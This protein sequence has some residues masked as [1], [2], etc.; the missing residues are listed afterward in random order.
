MHALCEEALLRVLYYA[1]EELQTLWQTGDTRLQLKLR[2]TVTE[3]H[4]RLSPA[5]PEIWQQAKF[6][7]LRAVALT[8]RTN[9]PKRTIDE[10]ATLNRTHPHANLLLRELLT[11][12]EQNKRDARIRRESAIFDSLSATTM[13]K[14]I[15][16][17]KVT[18]VDLGRAT[19][20]WFPNLTSLALNA[21]SLR[22][23]PHFVLAPTL[24]TLTLADNSL[25]EVADKVGS[26][27]ALTC[28]DLQNNLI[29]YLSFELSQLPELT[30]LNLAHNA[31]ARLPDTM[32]PPD[33][34]TALEEL[35]LGDNHLEAPFPGFYEHR[36]NL[37]ALNLAGANLHALP[38]QVSHLTNLTSLNV[39]ACGLSTLP[40]ELGLLPN[41]IDLNINSDSV[42][43]IPDGFPALTEL[44]ACSNDSIVIDF[45]RACPRLECLALLWCGAVRLEHIARLSRLQHLLL[46]GCDIQ[47]LPNGLDQ[48]VNLEWLSVSECTDLMTISESVLKLPC[49]DR[50][51]VDK[52]QKFDITPDYQDLVFVDSDPEE[53]EDE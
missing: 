30:R 47:T 20:V 35:D 51:S 24:Q 48:C 19:Q 49:L 39:G 22:E 44:Q 18:G 14:T 7:Q 11:K 21:C 26:F 43:R 42:T 4:W 5:L 36:S 8:H 1:P 10:R 50:V 23:W 16:T 32:Y 6:A 53:E 15:T 34:Y 17:L 38:A 28:L 31:M 37:R 33:C 41:L 3:S 25:Q 45:E 2:A 29:D 12:K 13:A 46:R 27:P 9:T 52:S 40:D